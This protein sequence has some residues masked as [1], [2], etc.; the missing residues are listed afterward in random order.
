MTSP[1][2]TTATTAPATSPRSMAEGMKPSSQGSRSARSREWATEGFELGPAAG[3]NAA[4]RPATAKLNRQKKRKLKRS[5]GHLRDIGYPHE[6]TLAKRDV[7]IK[8]N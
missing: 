6:A 4:A 7:Y 2:L 8:R 3:S 5:G 1:F